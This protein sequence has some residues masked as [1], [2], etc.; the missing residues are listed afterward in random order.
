M[1]QPDYRVLEKAL[2]KLDSLPDP[3]Y[4][5]ILDRLRRLVERAEAIVEKSESYQEK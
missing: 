3:E 2:R 4:H 1:A 5:R